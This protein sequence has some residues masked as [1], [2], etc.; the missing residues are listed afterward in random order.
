APEIVIIMDASSSMAIDK[1]YPSSQVASVLKRARAGDPAALS[2]IP[3]MHAEPE[4]RRIDQVQ[5]GLTSII[6]RLP[7]DIDIGFI[8]FGSCDAVVNHKFYSSDQRSEL[9]SIINA[10][11]P[12]EGRPLA[13][14]LKR[15]GSIIKGRKERDKGVIILIT[16]G[17]G[18]CGGDVC[19]VAR[20]IAAQKPGVSINVVSLGAKNAA[21]C[22]ANLTGGR[23]VDAENIGLLQALS[24]A[25]EEKLAT[26]VCK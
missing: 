9:I 23:V 8:D 17:D 19:A 2:Q 24:D 25:S 18:T 15:G 3:S 4:N 16:D 11:E 14:A 6:Q 10:T 22:A 13:R 1:S 21:Q 20:N 26:S 7:S 12:N 5:D